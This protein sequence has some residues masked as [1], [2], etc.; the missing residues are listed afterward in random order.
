M[1]LLSV[2]VGEC[3]ESVLQG[4]AFDP[5]VQWRTAGG[6]EVGADVRQHRPGADDP[7][8]CAVA[9]GAVH[10]GD[11]AEVSDVDIV[12]GEHHAGLTAQVIHD[13]CGRPLGDDSPA[14]EHDDPV[15]ESLCLLDIVGDQYDGRATVSNS[16]H[17]VPRPP[18][19]DWV[20]VLSQFVKEDQSWSSDQRKCDEEALTFAAR[21][22]FEGSLPQGVELPFVSKLVEWPRSG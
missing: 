22:C 15:A 2:D 4:R 21:Q 13:L 9:L 5:K 6:D 14:V 20:E 17:N 12:I 1:G 8:L 3:D 16:T 19:P 10:A 7:H 18:S 11:V